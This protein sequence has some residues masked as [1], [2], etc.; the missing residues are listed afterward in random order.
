[1]F[2][3]DPRYVVWL[4]KEPGQLLDT[5]S[6]QYKALFSAAL[7]AFELANAVR[8]NRYVQNR[9]LV[10][11]VHAAGRERLAYRHGVFAVAWVLAKRARA[12]ARSAALIDEKKLTN[13]LSAP[14]DAFAKPLGPDEERDDDQ[15]SAC[16]LSEPGRYDPSGRKLSQLSTMALRRPVSPTKEAT[17]GWPTISGG[18]VRIL[19]F[20]SSADR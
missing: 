18:L 15:R 13:E 4:K 3:T 5:M 10:E 11:E 7:T 8:L 17:K 19:G 2:Q 12:A 16:S 14:F 20:E 6:D 9:M 1:M